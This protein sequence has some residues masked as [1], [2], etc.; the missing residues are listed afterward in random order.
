MAGARGTLERVNVFFLHGFLGRPQDWKRVQEY[1]PKH[2]QVRVFMPDYFRE[3]W[4]GPETPLSEWGARFNRWVELQ[5][6]SAE[7]NILVGYSLGGRLSLHALENKAN[8]WSKVVLISTNPGFDDNLNG[9][10]P[11]SDS[12]KQRWLQDSYWAE[13]F[14]KAPWVSLLKNWNDQPVFS[15]GAEEPMREEKHFSRELLGL[16]LTQWSLAQQRNMRKVID[17]NQKKIDWVI[18]EKDEKFIDISNSLQNNVPS[19]LLGIIPDCS[20]RVPFDRPKDLAERIKTL[21][22]QLF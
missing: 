13:E 22:H 3:G 11:S 15:G 19:L 7:K 6:V 14:L 17:S 9:F 1:L 16:A 18:G 2:E 21:V 12:R 5:G 4:L 10:E 8:L 20:H